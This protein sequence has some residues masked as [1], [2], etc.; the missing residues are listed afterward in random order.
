MEQCMQG[1]SAMIQ[2]GIISPETTVTE[3]LQILQ[4]ELQGQQAPQKQSGL[5]NITQ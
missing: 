5:G 3:L 2:Q 1:I 4:Q